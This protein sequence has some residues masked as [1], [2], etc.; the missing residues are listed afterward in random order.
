MTRNGKV[1]QPQSNVGFVQVLSNPEKATPQNPNGVGVGTNI[2]SI[3]AVI[4]LLSE[5]IWFLTQQLQ[6][7]N[8]GIAPNIV[9][10]DGSPAPMPN[11]MAPDQPQAQ[12]AE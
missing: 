1:I 3:P 9:L 2:K 12:N 10:P 7:P 11:S 4:Q 6:T 5:G 8:T